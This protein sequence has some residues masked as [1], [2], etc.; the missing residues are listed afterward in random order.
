MPTRDIA[1]AILLAWL[2]ANATATAH[3]VRTPSPYG[4]WITVCIVRDGDVDQGSRYYEEIGRDRCD[5]WL[6]RGELTQSGGAGLTFGPTKKPMWLDV[7]AKERKLQE[8]G[9]I[10]RFD[11]ELLVHCSGKK[12]P[13]EFTSSKSNGHHITIYRPT[14]HIPEDEPERLD[15]EV[16]LPG[17]DAPPY[18]PVYPYWRMLCRVEGGEAVCPEGVRI[19]MLS[20]EHD[21]RKHYDPK[22]DN[23]LSAGALIYSG[24][25][26]WLD[27]FRYDGKSFFTRPGM[28]RREGDCLL[29]IVAKDWEPYD[30]RVFSPKRPTSFRPTKENGWILRVLYP[31]TEVFKEAAEKHKAAEKIKREKEKRFDP[32]AAKKMAER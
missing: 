26:S 2:L 21:L 25:V 8:A 32:E 19:K 29:W 12:R 5:W 17:V 27:D 9:G 3:E 14:A 31:P 11:G 16:P 4:L 6:Y 22:V 20:A 1:I 23:A 30:N 18:R 24:N 28:C 15:T 7:N 10:C 13:T